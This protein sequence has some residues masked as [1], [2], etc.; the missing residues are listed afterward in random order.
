M[1]AAA[2]A[3][4]RWRCGPSC[5]FRSGVYAWLVV[6]R[7]LTW[8]TLLDGRIGASLAAT[9][10]VEGSMELIKYLRPAPRW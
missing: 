8:I 3:R 7:L 1:I 4:R 10:S 9:T 5:K 6:I 2:R